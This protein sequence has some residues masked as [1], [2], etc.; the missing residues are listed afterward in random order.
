MNPYPRGYLIA[1]GAV[2]PLLCAQ[3][4]LPLMS[5]TPAP[6]PKLAPQPPA[7]PNR[8]QRRARKNRGGADR[9]YRL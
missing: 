3:S 9:R 5:D 6:E 2:I 4:Y 8:A 1:A 7:K